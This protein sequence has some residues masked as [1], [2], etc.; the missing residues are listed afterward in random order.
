MDLYY[1]VAGKGPPLI[2]SHGLGGSCESVREIV[3]GLPAKV[4]LYDNRGHGR[5]RASLDEPEMSFPA[6]SDDVARLLDHLGIERAFVGGVSMGSGVALSFGL[7][8]PHRVLGLILSRPAWLDRPHPPNL[9]FAWILAPLWEQNSAAEALRRFV[10][11]PYYQ[12]LK[13]IY[14]LAATSLLATVE[15]ADPQRLK[16]AYRAMAASTPMRSLADMS[17]IT[18]PTAVIGTWNDPI[19]PAEIA[20]RWAEAIPGA[21]LQRIPPKSDDPEGHLREFQRCVTEFLSGSSEEPTEDQ[22]TIGAV[23]LQSR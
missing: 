23:R 22:T 9:E 6:M 16:V 8:L 20:E 21:R 7:R 18:V 14:P 12:H 13:A 5:S 15:G 17:A 10:Q 2:F 11:T 1:E 19:H 3:S 4:V